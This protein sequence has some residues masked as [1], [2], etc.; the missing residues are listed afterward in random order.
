MNVS[1]CGSSRVINV[2]RLKGLIS[3]QTFNHVP[4]RHYGSCSLAPR[5]TPLSPSHNLETCKVVLAPRCTTGRL[6]CVCRVQT[7]VQALNDTSC[8]VTFTYVDNGGLTCAFMV[9][10]RSILT[11]RVVDRRRR[12]RLTS[13]SSP[14]GAFKRNQ[15]IRE[16]KQILGVRP[17]ERR[18][19]TETRLQFQ[20][21]SQRVKKSKG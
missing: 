7:F 6:C 18:G 17:H 1:L 9:L 5:R 19:I 3:K 12:G 8:F 13:T 4:S 14:W 2:I 15:R 20:S 21:W 11:S 16:P 10:L